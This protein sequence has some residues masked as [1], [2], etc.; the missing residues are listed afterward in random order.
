MKRYDDM[1]LPIDGY[2]YYQ[3]VVDPNSG[4]APSFSFTTTYDKVQKV[5]I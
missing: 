5:I 3:H 1:G 2:N 4:G